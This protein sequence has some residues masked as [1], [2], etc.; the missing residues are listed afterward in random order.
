M[1]SF[2]HR[3]W[4]AT[5]VFQ[6]QYSIQIIRCTKPECC[7]PWRSNYIQL[8]P[9]RFLPPPVPFNRSSRGVRLAELDSSVADRNPISPYYGTLY[10]RIQFH[11]I[12]MEG[13]QTP[14]IPYDAFCPSLQ[15]KLHLRIC[16]ICKQ[17]IPLGSRLRNHYRVHQQRY[18]SSVTTSI[19]QMNKKEDESTDDPDPIDPLEMP[20]IQIN[21]AKKSVFLFSSLNEWLKSDFE[22]VPVAPAKPKST[23]TIANEMIRREKQLAAI[24]NLRESKVD[25]ANSLVE[26]VA[27]ISLDNALMT[28]EENSS[29]INVK[30]E[31]QNIIQE[32]TTI[33]DDDGDDDDDEHLLDQYDDLNDLLDNLI[34]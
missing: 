18:A 25:V 32:R 5:H 28:N 19:D 23:A 11:G 22:E 27:T 21:P 17:Y 6:A 26:S 9:H 1:R 33:D 34:H 24:A 14:L 4:C 7:G 29:N 8:F 20:L 30:R 31:K 15:N 16:S 2:E 12:V 3:Y 10:Q 13:T